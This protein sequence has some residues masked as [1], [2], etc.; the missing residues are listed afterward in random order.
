M[1]SAPQSPLVRKPRPRLQKQ[2]E[3][4]LGRSPGVRLLPIVIVAAICML[5]FRLQVVVKDIANTP[6]ASV[7]IERAVAFAAAEPA[8][9]AEPPAAAPEAGAA[10]PA[11]D[12]TATAD[13][14]QE[15]AEPAEGA[16]AEP[17]AINTGG[18][19]FTQS[20]VETLQLL[21][22]RRNEI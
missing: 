22:D 19:N 1:T 15:A 17:V 6:T 5:G 12:A 7:I 2:A 11:A 18:S 21:S 16:P 9:P 8:A 3:G 10:A 4:G 14:G 20:E 13:A